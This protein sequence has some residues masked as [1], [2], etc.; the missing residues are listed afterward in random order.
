MTAM[1]YTSAATVP[2][3][4]SVPGSERDVVR[5]LVS[6]AQAGDAE[7]FGALYER[8]VG[9][10]HQ[11]VF[12]KVRRN[13]PLAEDLTS[14]VFLRAMRGLR[15]FTWQ[16]GSTFA[17]WLLTIARNLVVDY[18]K[19]GRTRREMVLDPA[20]VL[21]H[22]TDEWGRHRVHGTP[23]AGP[24]TDPETTATTH[25]TNLTLLR[26][27]NQLT[28]EQREVVL[29]RFW[30]QLTVAET[31]RVLGTNPG[32]VKSRQTR[33]LRALA[34]AVPAENPRAGARGNNVDNHV[35]SHAGT[36]TS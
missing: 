32:A 26:A 31:A 10:V 8:Y 14:E 17:G 27:I 1:T 21:E 28:S 11:F 4:A 3:P 34:R 5:G 13:R 24:D 22:H 25:E 20:E 30:M 16:E 18:I 29:L 6:R 19:S 36:V 2:V 15:R 35:G 23:A 12:F 9:T 7:A 33:A